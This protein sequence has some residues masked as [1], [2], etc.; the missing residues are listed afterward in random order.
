M[1]ALGSGRESTVVTE[2][3][4]VLL[5][6][7]FETWQGEVFCDKN[8]NNTRGDRLKPND[9]NERTTNLHRIRTISTY[10]LHIHLMQQ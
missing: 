4:L 6:L 10:T 9:K 3:H 8:K 1:G 5:L 7:S 2:L